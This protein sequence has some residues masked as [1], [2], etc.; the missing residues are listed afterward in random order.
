M[1]TKILKK[2]CLY[3][4]YIV[5]ILFLGYLFIYI[6]LRLDEVSIIFNYI[7]ILLLGLYLGYRFADFSYQYLKKKNKQNLS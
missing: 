3:S 1:R 7:I 4:N 5:T 6:V 2:I